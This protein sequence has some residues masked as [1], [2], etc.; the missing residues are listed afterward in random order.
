MSMLIDLIY[1]CKVGGESTM[2]AALLG[3]GKDKMFGPV[4]SKG[5]CAALAL[6]LA[7]ELPEMFPTAADAGRHLAYVHFANM[8]RG[9]NSAGQAYP[10]NLGVTRSV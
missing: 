6:M 4:P 9:E 7:A 1:V 10:Y 8:S 3:E 5:G 2:S